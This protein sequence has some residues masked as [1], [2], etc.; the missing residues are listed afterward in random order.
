[1]WS[2]C[3]TFRIRAPVQFLFIYSLRLAFSDIEPAT[4]TSFL[5]ASQAVDSAWIW[6][7]AASFHEINHSAD[8]S[9]MLVLIHVAPA[10]PNY[11]VVLSIFWLWCART[12]GLCFGRVGQNR[13]WYTGHNQVLHA[14]PPTSPPTCLYERPIPNCSSSQGLS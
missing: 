5:V 1:M 4:S 10:G 9:W 12:G 14:Q 3:V 8:T 13:A 7:G 11:C 6:G 2:W